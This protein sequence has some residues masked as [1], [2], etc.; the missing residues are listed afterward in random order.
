MDFKKSFCWRS[1]LS[2]DDMISAYT[3]SVKVHG[4]YLSFFPV[5]KSTSLKDTNL[6]VAFALSDP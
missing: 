2:N 6:G 4:F 1:N 3:R 5:V